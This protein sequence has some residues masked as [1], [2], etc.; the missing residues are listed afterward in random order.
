MKAKK[1]F[2]KMM[3]YIGFRGG[4]GGMGGRIT[5]WSKSGTGKKRKI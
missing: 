2:H 4:E 1:L 3:I 5:L